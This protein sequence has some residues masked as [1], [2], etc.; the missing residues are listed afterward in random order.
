MIENARE[1]MRKQE[2]AWD[3]K[4]MNEKAREWMRMEI[5]ERMK[6]N[7]EIEREVFNVTWDGSKSAK[8]MYRWHKKCLR[9]WQKRQNL[10][11]VSL[12][13]G[14]LGN[15]SWNKAKRHQWTSIWFKVQLIEAF[16]ACLWFPIP[17]SRRCTRWY[18]A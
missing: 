12:I 13:F 17:A 15:S 4:R 7:V 16:R 2:N 10:L 18:L 11:R 6:T 5:M 14:K 3:S 1:W 9:M 8:N